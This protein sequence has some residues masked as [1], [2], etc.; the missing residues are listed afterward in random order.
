M[1]H[2]CRQPGHA[3][4]EDEAANHVVV[5]LGPDDENIGNRRIRDPVL[6][7]RQLPA[8]RH[9]AGA[10]RQTAGVGTGI[11][12]GQ[13][14]AAD[15]L[16]LAEPGQ[17]FLLLLLGAEGI[18]RQHDQRGLHAEH[19]P[20]AGIDT[21]DFPRNESVGD[22]IQP[23]T[24]VLR[25]QGWAEQSHV[26]HFP[27]DG[28]IDGFMT[29]GIAN[30]RL[31]GFL[32]KRPGGVADLAFVG[33]QLRIEQQRVFPVESGFGH[34]LVPKKRSPPERGQKLLDKSR[35][36]PVRARR[37]VP[38]T[39]GWSVLPDRPGRGRGSCRSRCQSLHRDHIQSRRRSGS[40]R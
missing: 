1:D 29:K 28:R 7:A 16:A 35:L 2:R 32:G 4:V 15:P 40:R 25:R 12:L 21:L 30:A 24:A 17:V 11:R 36:R 18:D 5:V 38:P 9:G 22:V 13:A 27:E 34:G 14:K 31:Q 8:A 23:G 10:G 3:L 39:S 6:A 19:R 26:A 37:P 20:V 33:R